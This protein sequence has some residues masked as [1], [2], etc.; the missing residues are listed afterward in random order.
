[1]GPYGRTPR[2][3]VHRGPRRAH[4]GAAARA[5]RSNP[6]PSADTV[7]AERVPAGYSVVVS[8]TAVTTAGTMHI[9][10]L[11]IWAWGVGRVENEGAS[12]RPIQLGS[13]LRRIV[14]FRNENWGAQIL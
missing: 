12:G 8:R 1:M 4:G 13:N 10:Q 3:G 7:E 6:V 11:S 5:G 14:L 9:A 2:S